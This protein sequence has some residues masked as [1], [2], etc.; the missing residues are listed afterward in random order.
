MAHILCEDG[1]V[2]NPHSTRLLVPFKTDQSEFT[3]MRTVWRTE[4][5]KRNCL[6]QGSDEDDLCFPLHKISF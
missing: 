5:K 3:C 2:I 6:L 1:Q 4:T